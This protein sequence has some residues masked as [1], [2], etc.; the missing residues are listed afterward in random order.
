VRIVFTD[1]AKHRLKSIKEYYSFKV[2]STLA[3]QIIKEIIESTKPLIFQPLM[4]QEEDF[5][6]HLNLGHRYI[7]SGNYKI[8]YRVDIETIYIT[9]IFDTRQNPDKMGG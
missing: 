9:D 8:L 5:L 2:S 4:G 6:T 3:I 1:R 7:L